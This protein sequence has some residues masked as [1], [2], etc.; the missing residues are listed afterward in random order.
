M[1]LGVGFLG[2]NLKF[3]TAQTNENP[4]MMRNIPSQPIIGFKN[5]VTSAKTGAAAA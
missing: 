5:S 1:A 3:K 4:E 2:K